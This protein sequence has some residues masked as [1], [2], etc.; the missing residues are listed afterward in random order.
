LED[1]AVIFGANG[2][3]GW[4]LKDL[5]LKR[6][7]RVIS[8][9]RNSSE[10]LNGDVG[11]YSFV[12]S[13]IKTTQPK[14]IFHLAATSRVSHNFFRDNLN[15]I[16]TGTFNVLESVFRFSPKSKVFLA[17]S[18]MQF[19]NE[20]KPISED[21]PRSNSTQYA[22]C[23]NHMVE[24]VRYYREPP[25]N[26]R[27]YVG[28]LFH[29][30]STLRSEGHLNQRIVKTLKRISLGSNEKLIIGDTSIRK[31]YNFAGDI[32][33]AVWEIINQDIYFD[34]VVGSGKAYSIMDW[35]ELCAS[36]LNLNIEKILEYDPTFVKPFDLL[37]SNPEK[38]ISTG[39]SPEIDIKD[40]CTMML[41][42]QK[43]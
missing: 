1:S 43:F 26:L 35:I 18:A 5:L 12:S 11:D 17:G 15:S 25:F 30:D 41:N 3:D 29:H 40:L 6:N 10:C 2:Q 27:I 4:Y 13:L 21:S 38:L 36:N 32:V 16:T 14:F 42:D 22:L 37:I 24:I 31:E 20:G 8:V 39:W 33:R 19:E 23:R 34:L 7:I 28:Y 9:S